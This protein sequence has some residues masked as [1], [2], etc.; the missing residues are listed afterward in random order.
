MTRSIKESTMIVV[1]KASECNNK[2]DF[3]D[4]YAENTFKTKSK[5]TSVI[6]YA[7][8]HDYCSIKN[9][10]IEHKGSSGFLCCS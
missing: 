2:I 8:E 10:T 9:E 6:K 1:A 7:S 3:I 4:V 5:T